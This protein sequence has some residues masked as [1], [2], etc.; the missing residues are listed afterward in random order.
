MKAMILAAGLGS[1]LGDLTKFKPK[2]ILAFAN[3]C[4]L[5]LVVERLKTCGVK[6]IIINLH[7]L[8][9]SIRQH[10]AQ[11]E[12]YGIE[13]E[14]SYEPEILGTGGGIKQAESFFVQQ[15]CFIV[16]NSDIY[17]EV[18][19]NNLIKVHKDQSNL[20]TLAVLDRQECSYLLFNQANLL[21]GWEICSTNKIE[22]VVPE[23]SYTRKVFT[24]IGVYSTDL[25]DFMRTKSGSFSL[26][27]VLL[28]ASKA[29]KR[30]QA[31]PVDENYWI[32]M[33]TPEKLRQLELYLKTKA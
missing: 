5:D 25:F 19:L 24:G 15:D 29:A 3:T 14:F 30:I 13:I 31:V 20:A 11:K 33:G 10:V 26:P 18:D 2:P 28:E 6:H 4:M 17:S 16:H 21:V 9:D 32:D 8:P 23:K 7:Y 27:E 1:R 22:L 12:N